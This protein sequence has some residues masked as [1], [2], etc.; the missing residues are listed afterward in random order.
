MDFSTTIYVELVYK[1]TLSNN[2]QITEEISENVH[3]RV[4][5]STIH[6]LK[7]DDEETSIVEIDKIMIEGKLKDPLNNK[8]DYANV[9]YKNTCNICNNYYYR[10]GFTT[11]EKCVTIDN[12]SESIKEIINEERK[13]ALLIKPPYFVEDSVIYVNENGEEDEIEYKLVLISSK[14]YI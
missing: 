13:E 1:I 9:D 8:I 6:D 2:E 11:C 5:R 12:I 10:Y 7:L 14:L 4:W 3:D